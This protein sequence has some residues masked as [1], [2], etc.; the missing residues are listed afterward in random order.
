[1]VVS[2]VDPGIFASGGGGP[3]KNSDNVFLSSDPTFSKG[4][5]PDFSGG[6]GVQMLIS[7][8]TY[9]TCDF[10]DRGSGYLDPRM[11]MIDPLASSVKPIRRTGFL[12]QWFIFHCSSD[13]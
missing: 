2:Y 5:G 11:R 8:E 1:M 12:M 3:K 10:P 13:F 6:G 7:L 4:E 9:R